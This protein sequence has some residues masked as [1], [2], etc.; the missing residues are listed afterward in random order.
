MPVGRD[1]RDQPAGGRSAGPEIMPDRCTHK[2]ER[3]ATKMV[4]Y[5]HPPGPDAAVGV[6]PRYPASRRND[7]VADPR[8]ARAGAGTSRRRDPS[9]AAAASLSRAARPYQEMLIEVLLAQVSND[10]GRVWQR[11][12][13]GNADATPRRSFTTL[14]RLSR[15][16]GTGRMGSMP[17]SCRIGDVSD[18]QGGGRSSSCAARPCRSR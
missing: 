7:P 4:P 17:S 6:L 15:G 1:Q 16:V 18:R 10:A 2:Y 12:D 8:V 9:G 5:C 11:A 13:G 14:P 3:V